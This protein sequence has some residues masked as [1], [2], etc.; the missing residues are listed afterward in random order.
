MKKRDTLI[1]GGIAAA[2]A[3]GGAVF[4]TNSKVLAQYRGKYPPI[5]QKLVDK[6]G[7]NTTEV[8]KVMEEVQAE[9]GTR[10]QEMQA[11]RHAEIETKLTQAVQDGKLT[12]DQKTQILT[13]IAEMEPVQN[14][15]AETEGWFNL[16][17]EERQAKMDEMRDAREQRR[18]ELQAWEDSLGVDLDEILG[19]DIFGGYGG[20]GGRGGFGG[21]QGFK[22]MPSQNTLSN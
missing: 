19:Y 4:F 5:V 6:F 13:K 18:A 11:T 21:G 14:R 16:S 15:A 8:D 1:L 22:G 12:E 20:H 3:L 7:L 17:A 10:M 2:I 9:R